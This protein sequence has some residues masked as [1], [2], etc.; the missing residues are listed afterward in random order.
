MLTGNPYVKALLKHVWMVFMSMCEIFVVTI[1]S[2]TVSM[3]KDN[4]MG[5]R[6]RDRKNS[7]WKREKQR[8]RMTVS[9][10]VLTEIFEGL[11]DLFCGQVQVDV[12]WDERSVEPVVV[13]IAVYCV[14]SQLIMRQL[15]LK[16]TDDFHLRKI[17][18]VTHIWQGER[19]SKENDENKNLTRRRRKK[20]LC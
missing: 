2:K 8:N 7:G 14:S 16:Q 5:D 9:D 3:E 6:E 15:L 19:E 17:S 12:G 1:L 4:F 13:V 20:N 10:S 11:L 18:A